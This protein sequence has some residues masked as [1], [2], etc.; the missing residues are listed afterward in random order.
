MR[1]LKRIIIAQKNSVMNIYKMKDAYYQRVLVFLFEGICPVQQFIFSIQ[2]LH[3]T[4]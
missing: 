1:F 4:F 2:P 3:T